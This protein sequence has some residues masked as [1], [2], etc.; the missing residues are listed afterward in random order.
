M[1]QQVQRALQ[2]F[3]LTDDIGHARLQTVRCF[4]GQTVELADGFNAAGIMH[5]S[6][7]RPANQAGIG[8]R[9]MQVLQAQVKQGGDDALGIGAAAIGLQQGAKAGMIG[10]QPGGLGAG[11]KGLNQVMDVGAQSYQHA[12][13]GA[14]GARP[15]R[16]CGGR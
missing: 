10:V 12:T 13:P 5:G 6:G 9:R 7:M 8:L 2:L 15:C 4:T 16:I 14:I 3:V 1:A 11:V